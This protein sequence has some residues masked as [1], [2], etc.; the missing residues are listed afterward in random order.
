MIS[1]HGFADKVIPSNGTLEYYRRVQEISPDVRDFYRYFE[2]PGVAHCA[3]GKG[4]FPLTAFESLVKWVEE[5]VT[6]DLLDTQS[7]TIAGEGEE[8]VHRRPLCPW[9]MV[10]AFRG[11]G[12]DPRKAESFVCRDGFGEK[13]DGHDEL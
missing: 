3:G 5:G 9:P 2:A 8:V 7:M 4:P 11:G 12:R 13:E 1:W 10:A 6:P